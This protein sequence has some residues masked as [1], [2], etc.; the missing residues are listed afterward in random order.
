MTALKELLEAIRVNTSRDW[1]LNV[2]HISCELEEA[3]RV[4][5]KWLSITV[6]L[7]ENDCDEVQNG[8]EFHWTFPTNET[9][10][11]IKVLV[12]LE[13]QEDIEWDDDEEID[14]EWN[15]LK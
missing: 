8:E 15:V 7:S 12:R 3:H 9:W 6:P 1:T 13:T 10:E 14:D 4:A 5:E 11:W 2:Q